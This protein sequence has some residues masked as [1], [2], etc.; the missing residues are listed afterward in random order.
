M[1]TAAL[2]TSGQANAFVDFELALAEQGYFTAQEAY[3]KGKGSIFF[4]TY[5]S[6]VFDADRTSG[7]LGPNYCVPSGVTNSQLADVA[8]QYLDSN[9]AKRHLSAAYL[10]RVSFQTAYPCPPAANTRSR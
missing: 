3:A 7:R 8:Y 10:M 6:A 9:P 4:I 5:A 2:L 1:L